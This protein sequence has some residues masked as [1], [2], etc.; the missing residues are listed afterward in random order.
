MNETPQLVQELRTPRS[1]AI[2]G[3]IF[4][5]ILG[6]VILL[7]Q[8]AGLG[9]DTNTT[10]WIADTSRRNAVNTAINLIPFAGIA[11]LWF[12]GVI[13]SRLGAREDKLFATVFLGSGLLFVGVLFTAA[14]I[15]ASLL[16]L[17]D[18]PGSVSAAT[19]IQMQTISVT[20]LGLF[21]ARMA[22]VFILSVT[23]AGSRGRV[24]PR[25]LFFFGLFSAI[26]LLMS[27]PAPRWAQLL[28]PVWVLVF[29][30]HVLVVS[31]RTPHGDANLIDDTRGTGPTA[32]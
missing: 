4:A 20:L 14:A 22:A 8:S 29:S 2:A 23:A 28:F 31:M 1:A 13:R 10:T 26:V 27:P 25:W 32:T 16:R 5:V 24:I 19:V 18:A 21:G 7:I 6:G 3:I 15:L 12:I 17:F 11:F 30:V 9:D